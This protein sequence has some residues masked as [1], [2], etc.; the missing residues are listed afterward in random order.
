MT[1]EGPTNIQYGADVWDTRGNLVGSVAHIVQ[2][3]WTGK[4]KSFMVRDEESKESIFF[5][6]ADVLEAAEDKITVKR[7]P[8]E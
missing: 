3:T 2:D 5:E 1:E 8:G 4:V 7:T 6:P